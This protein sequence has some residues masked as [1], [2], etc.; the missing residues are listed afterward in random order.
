MYNLFTLLPPEIIDYI[1]FLVHKTYTSDLDIK[2]AV[3][4]RRKRLW[5]YI[6]ETHY[7]FPLNKLEIGNI[8]DLPTS[9]VKITASCIKKDAY[10]F[11]KSTKLF[12]FK[13][14]E[15][16]SAWR[17]YRTLMTNYSNQFGF[18]IMKSSSIGMRYYCSLWTNPSNKL[19]Y[20]LQRMKFCEKVLLYEKLAECLGMSVDELSKIPKYRFNINTKIQII[21]HIMA[22]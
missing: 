13:R 9:N 10:V 16:S 21:K 6:T 22:L 4:F 5:G 11:N 12:L 19:L 20:S 14:I 15:C 18:H 1:W 3:L 8:W 2:N 17:Y 7:T